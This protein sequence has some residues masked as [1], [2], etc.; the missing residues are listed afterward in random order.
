MVRQVYDAD[1]NRVRT[2][3]TPSSGPTEVT[4]FLVD[5]SDGLS[6]VVAEIDGAGAL[7]ALYVRGDDLLAVIR[8]GTGPKFFHGDGLGSIRALTDDTGAVTDRYTFSAFGELL[9]HQG[10]DPNSYLFA[11]E[12]LDLSSGFYYLRARWMQ[13]GVGRFVSMDPFPGLPFEPSTLHRYLYANLDPVNRVDPSGQFGLAIEL[14]I[15]NLF[16]SLARLGPSLQVAA[17]FT[18]VAVTLYTA[19]A[20]TSVTWP[21]LPTILE[22]TQ[23]GEDAL[24]AARD[25]AIDLVDTE[26]RR[27]G[28]GGNILFHYTS[29]ARALS[30]LVDQNLYL[31]SAY[32]DPTTGDFLP[33]G[34]YATDIA[35][36]EPGWTQA[37]LVR[38]FYFNPWKQD[39]ADV[40]WFV[41]IC[42]DLPP[43]FEPVRG[44]EWVK[45]G[46]GRIHPI[47]ADKNPMP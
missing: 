12:P 31:T 10:S 44:R 19:G 23:R 13:P 16:G 43:L 15:A 25:I 27:R 39:K 22:N 6:Q 34:A 17:V 47:V 4:D 8:P 32:T 14:P 37:Q 42:N 9:D 26:T 18:L 33:K 41:A 36:W 29:M 21:A 20:I 38:T 3:V 28:C 11:G 40:S 5:P 46:T 2:E 35:P 7:A 45:P 24:E 30:I 1:G